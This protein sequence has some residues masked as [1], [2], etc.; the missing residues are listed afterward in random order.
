MLLNLWNSAKH[1]LGAIWEKGKKYLGD[2]IN[3]KP[4]NPL[5]DESGEPYQYKTNTKQ[6]G[7]GQEPITINDPAAISSGLPENFNRPID[8]VFRPKPIDDLFLRY[9]LP[10]GPISNKNPID[11]LFLKYGI[12]SRP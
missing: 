1:H 5:P 2:W 9:G 7:K 10:K 3:G 4:S 11:N 8:K 6:Y 12:K